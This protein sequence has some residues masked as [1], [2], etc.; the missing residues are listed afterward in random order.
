MLIYFNLVCVLHHDLQIY[1]IFIYDS[2]LQT[3]QADLVRDGGHKYFLSVLQDTSIPVVYML[4]LILFGN[5]AQTAQAA[6]LCRNESTFDDN[7]RASTERW[8]RLY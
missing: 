1:S 7:F 5:C 4:Y 6:K 3:C 8:P 2:Q